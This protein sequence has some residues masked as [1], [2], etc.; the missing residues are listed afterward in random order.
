VSKVLKCTCRVDFSTVVDCPIHGTTLWEVMLDDAV[1][2]SKTKRTKFRH[3]KY[4]K[5]RER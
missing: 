4:K 2:D 3:P 1:K 5:G